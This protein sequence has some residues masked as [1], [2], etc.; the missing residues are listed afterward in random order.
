MLVRQPLSHLVRRRQSHHAVH[1][2]VCTVCFYES[3][4]G[5]ENGKSSRAKTHVRYHADSSFASPPPLKNRYRLSGPVGVALY[6][7]C[8]APIS[9]ARCVEQQ[10][11]PISRQYQYSESLRLS[12]LLVY[13]SQTH[14]RRMPTSAP[15][16][17]RV[18]E[19]RHVIPLKPGGA[20][21]H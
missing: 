11:Q 21:Y 3:R 12:L 7:T 17:C 5:G 6:G 4:I 13:L 19:Q 14:M 10:Q 2:R 8:T 15:A 16:R 20:S 9:R 18:P 1:A